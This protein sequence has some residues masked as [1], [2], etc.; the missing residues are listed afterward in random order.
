MTSEQLKKWDNKWLPIIEEYKATGNNDLYDLMV[1]EFKGFS[2]LFFK[3]LH[4]N[5]KL[6][7]SSNLLDKKI[8]ETRVKIIKKMADRYNI[9]QD[10]TRG[11]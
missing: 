4:E 2:S 11:K 7:Y 8:Y 5:D 1:K 3:M 9:L 6:Q 10:I